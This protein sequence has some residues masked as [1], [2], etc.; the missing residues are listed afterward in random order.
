[1]RKNPFRNLPRID[2]IY[3]YIKTGQ[4]F[5][6]NDSQTAETAPLEGIYLYEKSDYKVNQPI[7]RVVYEKD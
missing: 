2:R 7:D 4:W 5:R 3:I 1:M 6:E